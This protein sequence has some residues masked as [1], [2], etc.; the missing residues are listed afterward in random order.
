MDADKILLIASGA[1]KA[2]AV[3]AMIEGEP[4]IECPASALQNHKD[5]V[6]VL[7]EAAASKLTR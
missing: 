4:T 7:D 5:V 3:K 1:D 2:D 6:V